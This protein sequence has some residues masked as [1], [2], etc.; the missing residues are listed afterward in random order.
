MPQGFSRSERSAKCIAWERG[1]VLA[2]SSAEQRHPS[3]RSPLLH[4]VGCTL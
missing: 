2:A 1:R 4:L 3:I